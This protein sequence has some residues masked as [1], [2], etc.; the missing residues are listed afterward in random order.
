MERAQKKIEG[1]K[2]GAMLCEEVAF[3]PLGGREGGEFQTE[4][5]ACSMAL[6]WE[7]ARDFQNR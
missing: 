3:E 2:E 6:N 7:C 5:I 4:G 1:R